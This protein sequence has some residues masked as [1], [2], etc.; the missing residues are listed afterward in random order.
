M[1]IL[2]FSKKT[3]KIKTFVNVLGAFDYSSVLKRPP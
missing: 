3:L 2:A 1:L